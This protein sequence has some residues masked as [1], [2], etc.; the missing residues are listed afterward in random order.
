MSNQYN[1]PLSG[2]PDYPDH[3]VNVDRITA[4]IDA[5]TDIIPGLLDVSV[6]A[7][8]C[9]FN[10]KG[11]LDPD[12]YAALSG[13]VAE[14]DGT[15]ETDTSLMAVRVV[16]LDIESDWDPKSVYSRYRGF[17][18]NAFSGQA[19]S[20][21]TSTLDYDVQVVCG[22]H[23]APP[24]DSH[25]ANGDAMSFMIIPP[26]NGIIG[27]LAQSA[28]E[29][30]TEIY[31]NDTVIANAKT[32]WHLAFTDG[33]TFETRLCEIKSIDPATNKITLY[34][35]ID[36]DLAAYT[37]VALRVVYINRWPVYRGVLQ[38]FADATPGASTV[39][40]GYAFRAVYHHA[41]APTEDHTRQ[42]GVVEKY[43]PEGVGD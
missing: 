15:P 38:R 11:P 34:E 14:H 4:T 21:W 39:P 12:S 5:D 43:I 28:S 2:F 33:A 20:M 31:V 29:D 6:I 3:P 18:I 19:E 36:R 37:Y 13:V 26:N 16:D 17:T 8:S 30:D 1:Y 23:C 42:F 25:W 40:S 24:D 27:V 41:E 22:E 9:I 32:H 7:P 10:F 35:G